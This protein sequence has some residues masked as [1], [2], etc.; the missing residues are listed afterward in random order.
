MGRTEQAAR[1]RLP[2]A[3]GYPGSDELPYIAELLQCTI[4]EHDLLHSAQPSFSHHGGAE[5][6][7]PVMHIGH[8]LTD[9]GAH[10]WVLLRTQWP[11]ALDDDEDSE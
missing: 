11:D 8:T 3:A 10:H 2:G 5:D 7:V 1:L 4:V 9:R 6:V